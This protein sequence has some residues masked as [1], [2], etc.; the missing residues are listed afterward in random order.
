MEPHSS[1]RPASRDSSDTI[2]VLVAEPA[3]RRLVPR[4]ATIAFRAARA[5]GMPSTIVLTDDRTVRRLNTRDRG[6][7]TPTNV[8]TYDPPAP[9]LPGQIILAL[10]TVRREASAEGRRPAH[11]LAH[12]VVHGALHLAGHDHQ[13]PG[14]AVRMERAETR[15]MRRLGMPNPWNR[16]SRSSGPWSGT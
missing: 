15:L 7:N 1:F 3:W 11:H 10:G 4:A 9:G 13:H 6:R 14:E 2:N 16:V 5:A 8:L 12:L